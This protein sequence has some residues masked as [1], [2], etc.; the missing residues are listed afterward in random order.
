MIIEEMKV[1]DIHNI[2]DL[3]IDYYNNIEG[4]NWIKQTAYK[5]I[6]QVLTMEDSYCLILKN[7]NNYIGFIIGYFK[8]YDDIIGYTLEE[9][10]IDYTFQNRGLGS[11]FL[12]QLENKVKRLGASCIEIKSVNDP[13]HNH[14]YKINGYL[15]SD[16]FVEKVKWFSL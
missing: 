14:F 16:S 4:S 1:K 12:D 15:D 10:V 6:H 8:Q 5:R 9:I 11:Q 7:D 3:Y 13:M 2:L